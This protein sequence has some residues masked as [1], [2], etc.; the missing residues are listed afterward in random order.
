MES[1]GM[2]GLVLDLRFNPGGILTSAVDIA[3]MV[4]R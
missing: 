4:H 2:K 3:D 1:A